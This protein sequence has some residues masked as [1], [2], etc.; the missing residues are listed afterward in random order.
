MFNFFILFIVESYS[1]LKLKENNDLNKGFIDINLILDFYS[2]FLYF[3][4]I[5]FL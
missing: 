5:H 2:G 3:I 4:F 1:K